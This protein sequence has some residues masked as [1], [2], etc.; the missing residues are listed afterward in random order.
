MEHPSARDSVEGIVE[1]WLLQRKIEYITTNVEE[2]LKELVD[3]GL[4][5][6][7]SGLDAKD[8]YWV[9]AEKINRIKDFLARTERKS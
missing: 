8:Y 3:K 2:V 1:W 9:N 4:I 5:N 7:E 6:V